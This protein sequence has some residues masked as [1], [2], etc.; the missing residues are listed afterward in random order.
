MA[1]HRTYLAPGQRYAH[2]GVSPWR[3]DRQVT[4]VHVGW[5]GRGV[6]RVTC[7]CPNGHQIV[8]AVTQLEAE[9]S[10]G[11]FVPVPGGGQVARC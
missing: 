1:A 11:Q 4:V 5:D 7:Q 3:A 9:I 8:E 6:L 10:A 2:P